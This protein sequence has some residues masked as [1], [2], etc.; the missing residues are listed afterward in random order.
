MFV[1]RTGANDLFSSLQDMQVLQERLNRL[2]NNGNGMTREFPPI[3]IWTSANGAII[4]AE[5][6]GME[7]NDVDVSLVND[8][9][10]IK[11][12]CNAD[13]GDGQARCHR[14]ERVSGQFTRS[15]QLP[16]AVEPDRIA[17]RFKD[18]VLE[19]TLPRAEAE[20]PRKISIKSS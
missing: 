15:F 9:L 7:P 16:F 20:K 17:A 8:T 5:I 13:A 11:G 19:V 18:G 14:K 2:L 3:N 4:R 1:R 12:A 6:P 10:T